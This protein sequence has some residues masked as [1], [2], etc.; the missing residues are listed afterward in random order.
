MNMLVIPE[1]LFKYR[2]RMNGISYKNLYKQKKMMIDISSQY[3]AALKSNSKYS[4][5]DNSSSYIT[6]E[7]I[8]KY[9]YYQELY[10]DAITQIRKKN[11]IVGGLNIIKVFIGCKFKRNELKSS[12][13]LKI[14]NKF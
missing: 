3:K 4:F 14:I 12:V 1:Y 13:F 8:D 7:E 2:L 9:S 10:T 6:Q 5:K 11:I